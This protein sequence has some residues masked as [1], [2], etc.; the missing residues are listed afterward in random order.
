MIN[1]RL[2]I[3]LLIALG[4]HI[5]IMT[6]VII[7]TP[8]DMGRVRPYT[9]INFLGPIL[10]KTAFDIMLENVNPVVRTTYRL[11]DL[12]VQRGYLDLT[13]LKNSSTVQEFPENLER[14]MD[15]SIMDFLAEVKTVPDLSLGYGMDSTLLS[16]WD[17][18]EPLTKDLRQVIYKPDQPLLMS[19]IYG[20]DVS[21]NIKIR[22]LI[23]QS[24]NVK[25]VEPLTTTGY[26]EL[27]ITAGK[28]VKRWV[29]EPQID[30]MDVSDEW[31][32]VEI[33]LLTGIDQ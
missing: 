14:N 28:F 33:I 23:D 11:A 9:K 27:D 25:Q 29:F 3:F 1:R 32:V 13:V 10:R 24:G 19:G 17:L 26:P 7:I 20:D 12:S 31:I 21:F 4:A 18:K 6:A 30:L 5:F 15:T 8:E 16:S 2:G 22:A